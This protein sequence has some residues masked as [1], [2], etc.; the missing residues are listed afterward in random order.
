MAMTRKTPAKS[1][2]PAAGGEAKPA[3]APENFA[4]MVAEAAY[5]LAEQ[6]GF[7]AG[8]EMEDWLAAEAKIR[9]SMNN[10]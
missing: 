9:A 2:D 4:A 3:A 6:R 8:F 10:A 5:Y 7:T 1:I